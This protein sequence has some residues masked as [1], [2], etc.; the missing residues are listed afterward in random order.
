[1]NNSIDILAQEINLWANKKGFWDFGIPGLLPDNPLVKSTKV[2]L[3]VTELSE[4]VEGIRKP[5]ESQL[6]DFTNE[7]EEI[8]DAIIRLLDYSGQ[9]NLRVGQAILAKMAFNEGR[10]YKHNKQF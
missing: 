4:L 1:M 7:E 6:S 3:V 10:S 2:M 5:V 8:A 9:Y